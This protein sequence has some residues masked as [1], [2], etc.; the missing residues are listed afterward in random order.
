MGTTHLYRVTTTFAGPSVVGGA[1][2]RI[3][4][5]ITGGTPQQAAT[6]ATTF[7]ASARVAIDDSLTITVAPQVEQVDPVDGDLVAA[8]PVTG[9]SVAGQDDGAVLPYQI[10]SVLQL[11]TGV[12]SDGREIR[13]RIYLPGPSAS[14]FA[15]GVYSGTRKTAVEAA[16][17]ALISDANSTLAIWQRPRE[18]NSGKNHDLDQRD[19]SSEAVISATLWSKMASLRSRRD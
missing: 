6:A 16:G 11:R 15:N 19:G 5:L 10:Q 13:G 17:A 12:F 2:S 1:I 8:V 18:A 9:S 3:Y 14:T 7:W 4:F